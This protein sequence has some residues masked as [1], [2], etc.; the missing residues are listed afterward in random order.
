MS[1]GKCANECAPSSEETQLIFTCSKSTTETL[2]KDV[3]YVQS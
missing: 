3:K 1:I 2:G